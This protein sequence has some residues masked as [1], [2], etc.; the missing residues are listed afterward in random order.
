MSK[1]LSHLPNFLKRLPEPRISALRT[2]LLEIEKPFVEVNGEISR[3]FRTLTEPPSVLNTSLHT[4]V[5]SDPYLRVLGV[6]RLGWEPR[7]LKRTRPVL[8]WYLQRRG[9]RVGLERVLETILGEI[10]FRLLERTFPVSTIETG[11]ELDGYVGPPGGEQS[12]IT[13]ELY[14]PVSVELARDL[15]SLFKCELPMGVS[16]YVVSATI[17]GVSHDS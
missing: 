17:P 1:L 13:L 3:V 11:Q 15:E 6:E 9:T 4:S 12:V 7:L 2:M 14:D 8:A 16:A 10:R 5:A